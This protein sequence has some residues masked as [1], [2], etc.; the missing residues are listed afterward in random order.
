MD[1]SKTQRVALFLAISFAGSWGVALAFHLLGGSIHGPAGRAMSILYV[2]VP[3]LAALVV[4][5]AVAKRAVAEPLGLKP[6]FNG[7]VLLAWVLPLVILLVAFGIYA[8]WPGLEVI[9]T[10]DRFV[11]ELRSTLPPEA[12]EEFEAYLKEHPPPHPAMLVFQGL[13]GGALNMFFGVGEELGWRGYLLAEVEGG[14]WRR[15]MLTGLVWGVWLVPWVLSGFLYPQHPLTGIGLV[16]LWTLL[17]SPALVLLRA[18]SGTVWAPAL[19]R[20]TLMALATPAS[21]LTVGG[22]DRVEPFAGV[23]GL[24]AIAAV[25]ALL[26]VTTRRRVRTGPSPRASG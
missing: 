11:A 20:G 2:L 18:R 14:F 16:F 17:L 1:L 19:M 25:V 3:G 8:I 6:R 15:S 22:D 9:T 5:G 24:A 10:T 26:I 23:A 21:Q 7:W 13:L 4:Q 12:L